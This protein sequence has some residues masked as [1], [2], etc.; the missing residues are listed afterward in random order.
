MGREFSRGG[1]NLGNVGNRMSREFSSEG[2][3]YGKYREEYIVFR[4]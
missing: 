1:E 3:E 2:E 4:S